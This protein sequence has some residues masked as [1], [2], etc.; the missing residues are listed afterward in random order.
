MADVTLEVSDRF[1]VGTS[2]KAY[3][4][5][6]ALLGNAPSGAVLATEVVASDGTL[7]FTGLDAEQE[8]VAY[9]LVAAS[10]RYVHFTTFGTPAVGG[11]GGG[12]GGGGSTP[13]K[14]VLP[15][16]SF[17]GTVSSQIGSAR[18]HI[19][20]PME[21]Q[22]IVATVGSAPSGQPLVVDVNRL[23]GGSGSGTSIFTDQLA[24]PSIPVGAFKS[25]EAVPA[26]T[27]LGTGDELTVDVDQVGTGTSGSNLTVNIYAIESDTEP[28]PP[29][30][31]PP[32]PN[33]IAKWVATSLALSDGAAVS[34]WTD[35]I[36]GH[37]LTQ[38]TGGSQPVYVANGGA[39][40][41][42]AVDFDGVAD[43]MATAAFASP[44]SGAVFVVCRPDGSPAFST[45]QQ[46]FEHAA[47]DTW[48]A[49]FARY[50]LRIYGALGVWSGWVDSA[51]SGNTV[52]AVEPAAVGWHVRALTYDGA[53]IGL[54]R[55]LS[56]VAGVSHGGAV[57]SSTK[58]VIV[59]ARTEG[60]D[61]FGGM[62]AE[63]RYYGQSLSATDFTAIMNELI[64]TYAL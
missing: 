25:Q 51:T 53:S 20:F 48:V 12:G 8:F 22:A 58:P 28:A 59:G 4:A 23:A 54:W 52:Y 37:T 24:R 16:F 15:A 21:V 26:T 46:L 30:P 40:A 57:G 55:N 35:G 39:N 33:P 63:I 3:L 36:G 18:L 11:G 56:Q 61:F 45:T 44:I 49:P 50:A 62:V 2:V 5:R 19:P 1:P 43:F 42:P 6:G 64:A 27:A 29:P 7:E 41:K 14:V 60:A 38:A 10:H 32:P 34:S 13:Q 9:A 17:P 47:A 31:P